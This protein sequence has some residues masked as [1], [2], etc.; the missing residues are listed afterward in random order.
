MSHIEAVP[1][2]KFT[3]VFRQLIRFWYPC[4]FNENRNDGNVALKRGADLDPDKVIGIVEPALV[5]VVSHV[6]P[7]WTDHSA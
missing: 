5:V 4:P 3:D 6:K 7:L 2:R 1:E